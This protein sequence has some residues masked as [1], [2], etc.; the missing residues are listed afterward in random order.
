[1]TGRRRETGKESAVITQAC[2]DSHLK[3][4]GDRKEGRNERN[5][6]GG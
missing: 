1:M 4:G 5:N 2:N 6:W 3:R